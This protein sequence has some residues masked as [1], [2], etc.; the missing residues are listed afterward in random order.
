MIAFV[1]VITSWVINTDNA[2]QKTGL[3]EIYCFI[4]KREKKQTHRLEYKKRIRRQIN[5]SNDAG[6]VGLLIVILSTCAL[7]KANWMRLYGF[8][9]YAHVWSLRL[10]ES[11]VVVVNGELQL[12]FCIFFATAT[13]A[14]HELIEQQLNDSF[15]EPIIEQHFF[16]NLYRY[17]SNI[18]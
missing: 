3:W 14:C 13:V 1:A 11:V 18:A 5:E 6:A 10:S 4:G 8:C 9:L 2:R 17:A 7:A 16:S 15:I 12:V